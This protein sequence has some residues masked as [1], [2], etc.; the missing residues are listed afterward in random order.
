MNMPP[1]NLVYLVSMEKYELLLEVTKSNLQALLRILDKAESHIKE[2]GTEEGVL[3]SARLYPDM[4]DFTKQI[5]VASDYG[6]KD[7]ALLA[8]KDPLKMED[9][10][11]TITAL[12]DRVQKS[13]DVVNT[14]TGQDFAN[15]DGQP[16]KLFWFPEGMHVKGE[17]FLNQFAVSNFLFHVVTAYDILRSQGVPVGKADFIGEMKFVP[18]ASN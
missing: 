13:L 1:R 18:D 10:E 4:M 11:T 9:N 16:I 15:A 6:R 5:Q 12:K 3:L 14:F 17:D 2:K 8:G 7:L